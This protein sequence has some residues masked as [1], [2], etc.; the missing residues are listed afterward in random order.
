MAISEACK[1]EIEEDVDRACAERGVSKN[2]AFRVLQEFYNG[3]GIVISFNTIRSKYYRAKEP[4]ANATPESNTETKTET[5][6]PSVESVTHPV[7]DRGGSRPGAGRKPSKK[8]VWK[9]VLRVLTELDEYMENK[10]EL[11]DE[12]EVELV[13][14]IKFRLGNIALRIE[15][16]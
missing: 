5:Y 11:G 2:E 12:I 15:D 6:R 13:S 16:L 7:T 9:K 14:K 3:L 1:F 10:C 4:V 8:T